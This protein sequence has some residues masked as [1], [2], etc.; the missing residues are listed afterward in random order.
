MGPELVRITNDFEQKIRVRICSAQSRQKIYDDVRCRSLK[1]EVGN[2]V[3]LRVASM[4]R[5]L[6]FLHKASLVHTS[7]DLSKF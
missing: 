6:I 7:S 2:M 5:V 3:F 4:K 1:F